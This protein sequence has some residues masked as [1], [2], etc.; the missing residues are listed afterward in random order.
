MRAVLIGFALLVLSACASPKIQELG[1]ALNEP[2][3]DGD[4]A[5]MADGAR[6]PMKTWTA[7]KPKAVIIGVHG[8]NGYARDFALPGPWFAARN[9]SFYAYDQRSFGRT[10][11][12]KLGIWPGGDAMVSDLKTMYGL[13]RA[14]HANVPV[15]IVG[16]SMGGAVT[17]KAL[18]NGL[19]PAGAVL[20]APAVWGWRAMN[21]FLKSTLWITAHVAPSYAPTGE[22]LEIWPSDNIEELRAIGRDPL[23]L[24]KTRTDTIYGLVTLMDDAYDA[25]PRLKSP[26]LYLYGTNDQIV[27]ATPTHKVIAQIKAPKRVALYKNGWHMLLRD[28]QREVVW[29]DIEAWIADKAG[30]LP[31]GEEHKTKKLAQR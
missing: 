25:A 3:L 30:A 2:F 21:P 23:Y 12:D 11:K 18:D 4:T 15:Y 26:I 5:V 28:K 22:S 27:P 24:S 17:M 10:D 14:K 31:S 6:L 29:T 13:V 1:L 16:I 7:Q 19:D 8:M 9:I 20:V